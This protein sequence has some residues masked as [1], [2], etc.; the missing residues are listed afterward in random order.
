MRRDIS[1]STA[2]LSTAYSVLDRLIELNTYI[3]AIGD[4]LYGARGVIAELL[5]HRLIRESGEK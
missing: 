5:A 1:I 4:N 2:D 3:F